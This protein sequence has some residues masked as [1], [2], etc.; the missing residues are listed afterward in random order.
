MKNKIIDLYILIFSI[1]GIIKK[2]KYHRI[3]PKKKLLSKD[4]HIF[5]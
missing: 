3:D 2:N 4:L 5:Y 1:L